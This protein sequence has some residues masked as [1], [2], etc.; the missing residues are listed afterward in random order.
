VGL[1]IVEIII[2]MILIAIVFWIITIVSIIGLPLNA[3]QKVSYIVLVLLP[4]LV[5]VV[6]PLINNH[7]VMNYP[8]LNRII[9]LFIAAFLICVYSIALFFYIRKKRRSLKLG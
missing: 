5:F 7:I 6:M 9:V 3:L 2:L 1:G 4:I 8:D